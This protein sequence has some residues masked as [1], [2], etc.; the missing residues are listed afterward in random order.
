MDL[1]QSQEYVRI[2]I[3]EFYN[4]CID[5]GVVGFCIDVVKY[6]WFGDIK[7]I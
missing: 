7:V 3:V 2:K 6:M 5:V 1:D 4:Y